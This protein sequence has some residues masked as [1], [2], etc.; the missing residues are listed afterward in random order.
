MFTIDD[1]INQ[2]RELTSNF[3]IIEYYTHTGKDMY[4]VLNEYTDY[5]EEK[6]VLCSV[7]EGLEKAIDLALVIITK[8]KFDFYE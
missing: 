2:L 1:K 3:L 8:K 7:E 5:K 4:K 6:I